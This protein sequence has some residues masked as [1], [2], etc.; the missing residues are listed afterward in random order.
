[1]S[2]AYI[3]RLLKEPLLNAI[4]NA[5]LGF[6]ILTPLLTRLKH[7]MYSKGSSDHSSS[8]RLLFALACDLRE[9]GKAAR[10]AFALACD[11]NALL[12]PLL[13]R[14]RIDSDTSSKRITRQATNTPLRTQFFAI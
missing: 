4:S 5:V 3:L 13:P 8:F 6:H 7:G 9:L 1:M 10:S 14:Q 11:L 2:T 12:C